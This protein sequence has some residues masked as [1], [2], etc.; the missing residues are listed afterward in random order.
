MREQYNGASESSSIDAF[1]AAVLLVGVLV[2]ASHPVPFTLAVVALGAVGLVTR[3]VWQRAT[4]R[5]LT[6]PGGAARL[7]VDNNDRQQN[8]TRW[9]L[10]ISV[11]EEH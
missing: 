7:R 6:I 9:A 10:T 3:T 11:V 8:G 5:G 1:I 4:T 2:V